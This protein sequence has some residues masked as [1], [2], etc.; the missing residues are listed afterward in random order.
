MANLMQLPA[1]DAGKPLDFSPVANALDSN[2]RLAQQNYQFEKQNKLAEGYLGLAQKRDAREQQQSEQA[3]RMQKFKGL[4]GLANLAANEKDPARRQQYLNRALSMHPDGADL[5]P[6]Y[7]DPL[8]GPKLILA[9]A[10]QMGPQEWANMGLIEAN[11]ANAWA[12]ARAAGQKT[13][14]DSVMAR[15]LGGA[16]SEQSPDAGAP[17]PTMPAPGAPAPGGAPQLQPQSFQSGGPQ[18]PPMSPAQYGAGYPMSPMP[19]MRTPPASAPRRA[20]RNTGTEGTLNPMPTPGAMMS[21]PPGPVN[22]LMQSTPGSAAQPG[23]G[24]RNALMPSGDPNFHLTQGGGAPSPASPPPPPPAAPETYQTGLGP[25]T[26]DRAERLG[27][28]FALAGKGEAGKMLLDSV[29]RGE[30]G[31]EGRNKLDKDLIDTTQ[32]YQRLQAIASSMKPEYLQIPFRAKMWGNSLKAKFGSLPQDEQGE[33]YKYATFRR[34]AA[35]ELNELVKERSGGA[36]TPQEF[37]RQGVEIPNAGNG[38]F[39]GDDPVTFQAKFDRAYEVVALGFAR[40]AYLR[41]MDA[42]NAGR[43]TQELSRLLPVEQ[44]REQINQRARQIEGAVKQQNPDLPK[45]IV[46][47]EVDRLIKQEFGI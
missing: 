32:R 47:K 21:S 13:Q 16:L 20:L 12:Q 27:M 15:L 29:G 28:G 10:S 38:I 33:L 5:D 30:L 6:I 11:T 42:R 34:D 8:N 17:P 18:A 26:R 23:R 7:R 19:P 35:Q 3:V 37:V 1:Y 43:T 4:V 36:V 46:D 14:F 41:N 39:D 40:N 9:E 31:K 44:F 45:P 2:A 22:A 24:A 25:M